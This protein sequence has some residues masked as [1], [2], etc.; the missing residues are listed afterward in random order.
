MEQ[1]YRRNICKAA[2]SLNCDFMDNS[3]SKNDK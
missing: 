1:R 3:R 2:R